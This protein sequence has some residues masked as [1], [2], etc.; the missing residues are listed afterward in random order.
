MT[1]VGAPPRVSLRTPRIGPP[2]RTT[3]GHER[4]QRWVSWVDP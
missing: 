3:A 4:E 1:A 2:L